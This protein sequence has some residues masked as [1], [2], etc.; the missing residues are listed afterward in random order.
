M[1]NAAAT[2][3]ALWS[4]S[5]LKYLRKLVFSHVAP[6]L[7]GTKVPIRQILAQRKNHDAHNHVQPARHHERNPPRS[8]RRGP[9][10]L[11]H[12]VKQ[13]HEELGEASAHVP[14][15]RGHRINC[16]D[17][18]P[19]E[20]NAGPVAARHERCEGHADHEADGHIAARAQHDRRRE[21]VDEG[22][23]VARAREVAREAH[24]EAREDAPRDGGHAGRAHVRAGEAEVVADDGDERGRGERGDEAG[25]E[26]EPGEVEGTHVGFGEGEDF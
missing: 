15:P 14:P 24:D 5:K 25:A 4:F 2:V 13:R 11:D 6:L 23:A 22:A 17:N 26:G 8:K 7:E 20:H 1:P 10:Q 9:R 18:R 16:P 3:P 12:A 21:E 19:R